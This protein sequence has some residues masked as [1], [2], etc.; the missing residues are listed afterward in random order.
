MT[1]SGSTGS[2]SADVEE[3]LDDDGSEPDGEDD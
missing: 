2:G 3:S 1:V